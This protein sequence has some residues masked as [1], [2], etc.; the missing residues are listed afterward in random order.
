MEENAVGGQD[1]FPFYDMYIYIHGCRTMTGFKFAVH[2][3]DIFSDKHGAPLG[4]L[5]ERQRS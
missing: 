3:P 2:P 5:Q 4:A 1:E